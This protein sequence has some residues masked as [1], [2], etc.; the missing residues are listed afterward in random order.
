MQ[1]LI[2]DCISSTESNFPGHNIV[3]YDEDTQQLTI[4]VWIDE[5]DDAAVASM[6]GTTGTRDAWNDLVSEMENAC[7]AWQNSFD[8]SGFSDV[9]VVMHLLNPSNLDSALISTARGVLIYDIVDGY[10]NRS[11]GFSADDT[12]SLGKQNALASARKYLDLTAFSYEGLVR[13]LLYEG[14][15][16]GEAY[17]AAD[18][19][20]ANWYEQAVRSVRKYLDLTSFSRA[21][22]ISQ[23]EYEGFTHDQAVYAVGEVGY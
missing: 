16:E 11:S 22:L 6:I 13:Q 23:L 15:T 8:R 14:Y 20:G 9:T 12:V 2:N 10:S 19:C 5:M 1:S 4:A 17:Y 3:E 7:G 21:G 18:N